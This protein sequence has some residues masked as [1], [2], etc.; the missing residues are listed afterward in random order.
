VSSIQA[1]N[2]QSASAS[3][4]GQ[5]TDLQPSAISSK[6]PNTATSSTGACGLFV[7]LAGLISM[8]W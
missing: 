6:E 2:K 3:K 5:I 7:W 8:V 4:A 1:C